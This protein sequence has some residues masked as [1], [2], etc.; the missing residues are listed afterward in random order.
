MVIE[1][2]EHVRTDRRGATGRITLARPARLNALT[3]GMVA[4][5]TAVLDEWKRDASLRLVLIDG[6][7]SR[8]FC[9]GGDIRML[10]E[11]ARTDGA[12]A[13]RF[14]TDEYR[15]VAQIARFPKP[16]VTTMSGIV[17]GGGV[18]LGAHARHRIV[19]ESTQLA[20]PEVGIG[21]MPDAGGTWLFSR[22]PGE[23]GTYL[24]LTGEAVGAG[25]AIALGFADYFVTQSALGPLAAALVDE[26]SDSDADVRA[27]IERFAR[28]PGNA[29]LVHRRAIVDRT[30]AYDTVGEIA[31]ALAADGSEF[32]RA[33]ERQIG[34]RSPTSLTVTL[35]AL[36]QARALDL[37]GCLQL[38]YRLMGHLL[39]HPDFAEGVRA[40][41]IDKDR[42]PTWSPAVPA[43]ALDAYFTPLG[44]AE[45]RL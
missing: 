7:D 30:F 40:A 12:R 6:G 4:A 16:V 2:C 29:G 32:A 27:T 19:T 11:M 38:E 33:T 22:A 15:L 9:A 42:R 25:D 23:L 13:R 20:M 1:R 36:R 45:L 34:T 26:T 3:P 37:E 10:H 5:L 14:W 18:G 21:L 44:E 39:D 28:T 41:V 8:A 43:A 24:A 17:M 35:R 31:R